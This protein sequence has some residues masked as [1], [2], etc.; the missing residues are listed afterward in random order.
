MP[1]SD[2][3]TQHVIGLYLGS[4]IRRKRDDLGEEKEF[5]RRRIKICH[6]V[7]RKFEQYL[8]NSVFSVANS[9]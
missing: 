8:K 3:G 1:L 4:G 6:R 7:H 2:Q 5:H 9:W